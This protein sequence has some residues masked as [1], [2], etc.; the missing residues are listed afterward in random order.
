M[1]DFLSKPRVIR[2]VPPGISRELFMKGQVGGHPVAVKVVQP[3]PLP[4]IPA[5]DL[6]ETIE[7]IRRRAPH[8]FMCRMIVAGLV[9]PDFR[10]FV[11]PMGDELF[12]LRGQ[13]GHA[14]DE[15]EMSRDANWIRSQM[16]AGTYL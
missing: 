14:L 3:E 7:V 10:P 1:N 9:G 8:C 2:R 4:E 13:I 15:L 11:T 6:A 16:K 12:P 5:K